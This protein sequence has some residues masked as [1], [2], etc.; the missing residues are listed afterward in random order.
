MTEQRITD[1]PVPSMRELLD[2]IAMPCAAAGHAEGRSGCR[3]G[4]AVAVLAL[5]HDP[6]RLHTPPTLAPSIMVCA[7]RADYV[8]AH[9]T[10][11]MRCRG[12]GESAP[13]HLFSYVTERTD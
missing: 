4:P 7:G 6:E 12:C 13:L 5:V 3:P 8:T 11:P 2:R 1:A 9:A 10:E